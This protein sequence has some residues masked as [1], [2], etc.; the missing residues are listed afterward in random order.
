MD[1]RYAGSSVGRGVVRRH[2]RSRRGL[3]VDLWVALIG[4]LVFSWDR[5]EQRLAAA[6]ELLRG[7]KVKDA[8]VTDTWGLE[9]SEAL[10]KPAPLLRQFPNRP[11][12][13]VDGGAVIGAVSASVLLA[14][15]GPS[16]VRDATDT[17][18]SLLDTEGDVYPTALDA[19]AEC[20]RKSTRGRG[21]GTARWSALCVGA[22]IP[23]APT[24]VILR[25][26]SSVDYAQR[27]NRPMLGATS[28]R[29]ARQ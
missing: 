1:A 2:R 22:R 14:H 6:G 25:P 20:D 5:V 19:F 23:A 16:T 24:A 18:T 8:M 17:V 15:P 10:E 29:F 11:F 28:P 4:I 12:A 27:L 7:L 3:L 26:L 21:G 13:V 9:A